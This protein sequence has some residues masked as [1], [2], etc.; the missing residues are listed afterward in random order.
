MVE[1]N[2]DEKLNKILNHLSY[3]EEVISDGK[4]KFLA[5]PERIRASK[6]SLK[7]AIDGYHDLTIHILK[8][9]FNKQ[10][11]AYRDMFN[12]LTEEGIIDGNL[13]K[14]LLKLIRKRA[15]LAPFFGNISDEDTWNLLNEHTD[16]IKKYVEKIEEIVFQ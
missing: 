3:L 8:E 4:E 1:M 16:D 14:K 11:G 5:S 15:D 9:R 13:N 2:G 12:T 10:K 6:Y 7:G